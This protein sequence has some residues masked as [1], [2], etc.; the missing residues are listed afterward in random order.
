MTALTPA[1]R[2]VGKLDRCAARAGEA[3][4]S[5]LERTDKRYLAGLREVAIVRSGAL[6]PGEAR[7]HERRPGKILKGSYFA[8]HAG[9]SARIELY[10][11]SILPG[12]SRVAFRLRILMELQLGRVLFHEV[13]HHITR[14]VEPVHGDREAAA[15]L[16][17]RRL[18]RAA[19]DAK[20]GHVRPLLR[21]LRA[22]LRAL[23]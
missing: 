14:V 17:G 22:L 12:R 13:G 8:A 16:W 11:D 6:S 23:K 21:P 3:V 4:G 18:Q 2:A 10:L 20:Y 9:D 5:L 15:D 1:I 19:F 7:R